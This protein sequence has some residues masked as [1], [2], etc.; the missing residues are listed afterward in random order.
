MSLKM[1]TFWG[2]SM[3]SSMHSTPPLS[4]VRVLVLKLRFLL[5]E[6]ASSALPSTARK[7]RPRFPK[8]GVMGGLSNGFLEP[9][10]KSPSD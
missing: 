9:S 3:H 7:S 5:S 10:L 1:H 4:R 6:I 8:G 2:P